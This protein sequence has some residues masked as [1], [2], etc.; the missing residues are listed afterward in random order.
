MRNIALFGQIAAGKSTLA[1]A[2]VDAGYHKMSFAG[3]LK[4]VAALAY[5][6]V[7]KAKEYEITSSHAGEFHTIG[8]HRLISGREV[9]QQVGQVLKD[10]D[11]DFWL[12]CFMRDARNYLDTPLVVDDGRFLF[13]FE[14][15]R[16]NDWLTVGINTPHALRMQ[17]AKALYGREPTA[18]EQSHQSEVEVPLILQKVD[19]IVQGND[20][21]YDIARRILEKARV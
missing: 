10:V 15:L 13:E 6:P 1:A 11:R 21:S 5:G 14:A 17:R 8:H 18:A 9:L 3:P 12:K 2:L 4:N 19:M 16:D 7:D 20:E